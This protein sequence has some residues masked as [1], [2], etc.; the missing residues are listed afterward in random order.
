MRMDTNDD[1]IVTAAEGNYYM[2]TFINGYM[3]FIDLEADMKLTRVNLSTDEYVVLDEG[4]CINY[5][6]SE[7]NNIIYYQLE[8]ENDHKLCRMALDGEN[9]VVVTDGDCKNIHITKN[10]TYFY[11]I[12]GISVDDVTL[13]RVKT[14]GSS[15]QEV[16]FS[17]ED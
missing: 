16:N 6:V 1:R 7:E 4:K 17:K 5:N 8:N 12:T 10:Y 14:N 3:Y 11:K 13:F 9:K 2:P 15:I